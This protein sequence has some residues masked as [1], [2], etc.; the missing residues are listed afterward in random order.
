VTYGYGDVEN[1][2]TSGSFNAVIF[3]AKIEEGLIEPGFFQEH[4][5]EL[6]FRASD[7]PNYFEYVTFDGNAWLVLPVQ[8]RLNA[9]TTIFKKAMVRVLIPSG[10]LD[11]FNKYSAQLNP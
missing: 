4:Y 7:T 3:P 1:V 10:S 6:F 5:R 11:I 8:A 2:L 9:G